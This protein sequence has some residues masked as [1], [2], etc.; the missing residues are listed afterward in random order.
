MSRTKLTEGTTL[1]T[2]TFLRFQRMLSWA[3]KTE[4]TTQIQS[5]FGDPL[6]MPEHQIESH[7]PQN[8]TCIAKG[9]GTHDD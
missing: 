7:C 2:F 4:A 3:H 5:D 9:D 8:V 1:E 6:S